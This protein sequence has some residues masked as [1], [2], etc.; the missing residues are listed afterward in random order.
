MAA[1]YVRV[2]SGKVSASIDLDR[3]VRTF[4]DI[5]EA[6]AG[7]HLGMPLQEARV[8]LCSLSLRGPVAFT[9]DLTDT[10]LAALQ[11]MG[12]VS[13]GRVIDPTRFTSGAWFLLEIDSARGVSGTLDASW[14]CA[15]PNLV[16]CHFL[17]TLLPSALGELREGGGAAAAS[18]IGE[19]T[20]VI[21]FSGVLQVTLTYLPLF[22]C[23]F[24]S[25]LQGAQLA[26]Q[27]ALFEEGVQRPACASDRKR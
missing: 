11:E 25:I 10:V 15:C 9:D 4:S 24:P 2:V 20:R 13:L 6:A 21:Y 23:F 8:P 18:A 7:K 16:F 1:E 19:T 26:A 5:A 27:R 14:V 12:T 17:S 3:K 22:V